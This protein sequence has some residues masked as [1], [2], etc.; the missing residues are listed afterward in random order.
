MDTV[1]PTGE[2][3][4]RCGR[5]TDGIE[6][7]SIHGTGTIDGKSALAAQIYAGYL[8]N[9]GL[10]PLHGTIVVAA[11]VA[12]EDGCSIGT[13]HL[14]GRTLQD[15]GVRPD[16]AILGEPTGLALCAGHN[17]WVEVDVRIEGRQRIEVRQAA[18]NVYITQRFVNNVD[19]PQERNDN[20]VSK[21]VYDNNGETFEAKLCVCCAIQTGEQPADRVNVVRER[22]RQALGAPGDLKVEVN[23][24]IERQR[25]YT[26]LITEVK[27][28][29]YPWNADLNDTI[30]RRGRDAL[31]NHGWKEVAIRR[32]E[33]PRV[34]CGTAGSFLV[35]ENHVP[36]FGF[37]PGDERITQAWTTP[38]DTDEI[39]DAAFGTAALARS[40]TSS[41]RSG[42]ASRA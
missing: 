36:T 40:F 31:L 5:V 19:P 21:P 4:W 7:E 24:H 30:L 20:V 26:G 28:V 23:V 39:V 10:Q 32:W 17:G 8:L 25:L 6:G 29:V 16:V 34:R 2:T 14:M 3:R 41:A 27:K 9:T 1:V 37:G 38:I 15:L 42:W 22:M 18:S 35:N 33:Y 13:R 12:G 11:T